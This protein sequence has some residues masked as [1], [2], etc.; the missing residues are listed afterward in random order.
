MMAKMTLELAEEYVRATKERAS[1]MKLNMFIAVVD[2]MGKLVAFARMAESS[3]GFGEKI[4][5]AKAKTAVAYRRDTK[6]TMERYA[7]Y[8]GNYFIVGMSGLYPEE[9]WGGPGGAPIIVDGQ[10][11]GGLGVSGST[12]ENDHKCATEAIAHLQRK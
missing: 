3:I 12:P 7:N 2:E 11:L 10:L 9:F 5:I 6:E 8:P 1:Q 4:S